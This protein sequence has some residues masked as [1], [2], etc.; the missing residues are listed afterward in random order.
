MHYF[1]TSLG[2]WRMI[3]HV[4][5]HSILVLTLLPVA[6][7]WQITHVPSRDPRPGQKRTTLAQLLLLDR[8]LEEL[9]TTCSV[10][11]QTV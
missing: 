6:R 2:L 8:L 3:V 9:A 4:R 10:P 1:G 5:T 11:I 7:Y